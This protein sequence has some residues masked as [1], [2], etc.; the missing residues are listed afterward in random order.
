MEGIFHQSVELA[1]TVGCSSR[2]DQTNLS[3]IPCSYCCFADVGSG[4]MLRGKSTAHAAY[5]VLID[6]GCLVG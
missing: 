1:D 2:A 5:K 6:A 3:P 4:R